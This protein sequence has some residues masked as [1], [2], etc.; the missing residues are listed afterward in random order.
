MLLDSNLP[1]SA[2]HRPAGAAERAP[3]RFQIADRELARPG[4]RVIM[5]MDAASIRA[6]ATHC[7]LA[8]SLALPGTALVTPSRVTAEAAYGRP[9]RHRGRQRSFV[10][11]RKVTRAENDVPA[12]DGEV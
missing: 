9:I 4:A 10:Q 5:A 12:D 7:E 3:E 8:T 6:A 11:T 2:S 1:G